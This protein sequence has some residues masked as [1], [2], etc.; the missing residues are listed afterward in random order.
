ML[1]ILRTS[2][3]AALVAILLTGPAAEAGRVD[4]DLDRRLRL[5]PGFH[6]L[7]VI[8]TVASAAPAIDRTLPNRTA[9]RSA[10][11][12]RLTESVEVRLQPVHRRAESLGGIRLT[13]LWAA[14][15]IAL[16]ADAKA[17]REM[18]TWPEVESIRLDRSFRV[19]SPSR[20]TQVTEVGNLMNAS[21]HGRRSDR[22][23][24]I[25]G[26]ERNTE[27][28]ASIRSDVR[29]T[30]PS[31]G[32]A[33]PG[34]NLRAVRAPEL[35]ARG[36][37]GAGVV[38]AS[39]DTGVDG[40]HPDLA[41]QY[42]G[43]PNSWYDPHGEH[44]APADADG[45]GTQALSLAL[46]RGREGQAVG[47]A[48]EAQWIAAKLF[49]DA[50]VARESDLHRSLQWV[51]D[52]DG[53]P[54]TDDAPDIVYL[55]WTVDGSNRCNRAFQ[56]ELEILRA[57]GIAV[58]LSGGNAGPGPATSVSPANNPGQLSVGSANREFAVSSFSSRGPSACDGGRFPAV[59][60]PGEEVSAADLSFGGMSNHATVTGTSFA[61]PH[62]A[63]VLALLMS[64]VPGVPLDIVVPALIVTAMP[65]QPSGFSTPGG[66][67]M[68]DAMAAYHAVL[69][70]SA[71][72]P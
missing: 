11:L 54:A 58:V 61:A 33:E 44:A 65:V 16:T 34:W 52:P 55:P 22:L 31:D 24:P 49:N 4:P 20:K 12:R 47:V 46:G 28:P 29:V 62:V 71:T 1:R 25:P 27:P 67:G 60:A 38:L 13:T 32:P 2:G 70:A 8:V 23:L 72:M 39:L 43:G 57:S 30:G 37:K 56:E 18:A 64:A 51:L 53:D 63:G 17:I 45:H 50:G 26:G 19:W 6:K 69:A 5:S 9:I 42:R 7:P 14:H 21:R 40:A 15:A 35:W 10:I 59:L 3:S 68:I 48:P 36:I 66:R 41:A